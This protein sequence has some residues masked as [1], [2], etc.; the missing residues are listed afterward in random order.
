[1]IK[2][3]D[4]FRLDPLAILM[5]TLVGFV[6]VSIA[7]F[8]YR[9]LKGDAKYG[10]FYGTLAF[11]LASV[12]VMVSADHILLFLVAWGISNILLTKLM[13]HKSSWR[14]AYQSGI[15]AGKNFILGFVMLSTA[16]TLLYTASGQTSIHGISAYNYSLGT[17]IPAATLLFLGAMTQSAIWPF[18]RWLTSSLNA[19]T[20]VSAIMHAGLV[21]GGGFLLA[22]FAPLYYQL[23]NMLTIIFSIGLMSA[24]LGTLWKLMQSDIKRMLACS[25]MG[26]MGFMIVQCGLGLFPAA[27]AHLFT[28]GL[29]KAYLFLSS[30]SA[31]QEKRLDLGYPPRFPVFF[32][33]LLCGF[34][35]SVIFTL[36]IHKNILVVDTTFILIAMTWIAGAQFSMLILWTQPLKKFPLALLATLLLAGLY[37]SMLYCVEKV[38]APLHL[39]QPQPLN[40]VHIIGLVFLVLAWLAILFVRNPGRVAEM[41]KTVLN[42]YVK[43]LN[44]SQPHKKTI[45]AYRNHYQY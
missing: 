45:T 2:I 17:L 43:M 18:H 9:Y 28:H 34:L 25:T 35:G 41:P 42:L 40:S 36:A 21:N 33:A 31:A 39:M 14:A 37:G 6:G 11:L 16:I 22:R 3:A 38:L 32:L 5:I 15:L 8:S 23:P 26:Q 12:F 27:I 19:P 7:F 10:R 24:L 4:V 13:I 20:P 29:F 1:M 30:G 44:A